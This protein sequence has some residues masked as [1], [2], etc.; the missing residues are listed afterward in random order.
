[1][2]KTIGFEIKMLANMISRALN[3]ASGGHEDEGLTGMQGWVI[4]YLIANQNREVFQ[5]DLE[6][7]FHI[8]PATVT[9]VLK[10]MERNDLIVRTQVE[11][12]AR[13]KKITLTSKARE[14]HNRNVQRFMDFE[15]RLRSGLTEEEINM[16]C[17]VIEKL[18]M[19]VK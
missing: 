5:R 6:K 19:N 15:A 17:L 10:L 16:F 2:S 3:E 18:K 12:D 8:R 14:L 11:H 9:G 4:G 7:D 1:M 13:L